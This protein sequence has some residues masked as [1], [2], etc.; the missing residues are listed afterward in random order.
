MSEASDPRG[1][2]HSADS[3][4]PRPQYGEYATPEEQ[5]AHIRQPDVTRSLETGGM[6]PHEEPVPAAPSS[7]R[8]PRLADRI[9]T[10]AL[11]VY[12]VFSVVT[13]LPSLLDYVAY[14]DTLLNALGV[15]ATLADPSAARPWGFAAAIVL[16]LGWLA[17]AYVSWLSLKARRLTWWIPLV[18]G[19]VFNAL[20]AILMLVPILNDP[21][22]W[23]ALQSS[24][25][26]G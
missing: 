21:A 15:D 2:P 22:V 18:G 24:V 11:L 10:I 17:T 1:I 25:T 7:V 19:L 5:R 14:S 16:G 8:R 3:L 12:G 4:R 20:A 6:P 9:A 26:G 23:A 13:V